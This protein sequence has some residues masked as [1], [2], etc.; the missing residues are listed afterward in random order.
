MI[1]AFSTEDLAN[2]F[3]VCDEYVDPSVS[4]SSWEG[5]LRRFDVL[6]D[7]RLDVEDVGIFVEALEEREIARGRNRGE[8][9]TEYS[10]I[11]RVLSVVED[12]EDGVHIERVSI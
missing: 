6:S 10:P 2:G 9:V 7:I 4:L 12:M 11:A 1:A 3:P 8:E 5:G